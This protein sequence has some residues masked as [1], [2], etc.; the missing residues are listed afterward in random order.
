M[1]KK[2]SSE[3][4]KVIKKGK[5]NKKHS[6]I[7]NAKRNEMR[8]GKMK[9]R[10]KVKRGERKTLNIIFIGPCFMILLFASGSLQFSFSFLE[11]LFVMTK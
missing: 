5:I 11:I 7:S 1:L 2:I 9:E 4:P 6:S 10:E 3:Q 8:T